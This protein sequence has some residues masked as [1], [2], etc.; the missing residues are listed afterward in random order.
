MD[1][2]HVQA[3]NHQLAKHRKFAEVQKA[4]DTVLIGVVVLTAVPLAKPSA[5][6][7]CFGSGDS[8]IKLN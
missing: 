5:S 1:N 6:Q 4:M 8:N 7:L 3:G 2:P